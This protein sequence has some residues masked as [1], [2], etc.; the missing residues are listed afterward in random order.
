MAEILGEGRWSGDQATPLG[1][2]Y[3]FI[4]IYIYYIFMI[5]FK[6]VPFGDTTVP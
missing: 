3:I 5:R 4:Y 6:N 1:S 2:D